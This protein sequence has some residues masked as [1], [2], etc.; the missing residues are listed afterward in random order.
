MSESAT[1][2]NGTSSTLKK[3]DLI[4]LEDLIYGM[5][6]PSGNDAAFQIAL[7]GGTI[8]RLADA[9]NVKKIYERAYMEPLTQCKSNIVRYLLE[10][11]R[12]SKKIGM[13]RSRWVNPHGLSNK[14]NRT[15]MEDMCLLCQAVMQNQYIRRIV[16]TKYY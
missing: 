7:L 15:T 2:I 6:L 10:M 13:I 3:H 14:D 12:I 16:N 8:L 11:N 9:N 1:N 5:M 4:T